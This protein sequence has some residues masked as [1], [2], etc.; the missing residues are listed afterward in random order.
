M[1]H[2]QLKKAWWLA[3]YSAILET[4]V[5]ESGMPLCEKVLWYAVG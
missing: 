3:S 5:K 4:H 1:R 2:K